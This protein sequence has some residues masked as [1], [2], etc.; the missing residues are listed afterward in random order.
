L[1][2]LFLRLKRENSYYLFELPP[3]SG[4]PSYPR[5]RVLFFLL[6]LFEEEED[7]TALA[8]EDG[9]VECF[10]CVFI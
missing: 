8:V 7:S 9:G 5:G 1:L 4:T 3:P 6:L 10:A 2:I